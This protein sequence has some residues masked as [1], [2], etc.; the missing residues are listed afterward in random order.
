MSGVNTLFNALTHVAE[1][2]K[3]DFSDLKFA[4]GGGAAVQQSVSER[5]RAITKK[6]LIEGYGLSEASPVVCINPLAGASAIGTVGLPVPSTQVSIRD[7]HGQEVKLGEAGEVWV[8]GPQV[9]QG[10]WGKPE[11]TKHVLTD[12]GWLKTGDV[13]AIDERG[14]VRLLDRIKD[15][16][17]VSGFKVFPNEVEDVIA[18]HPGVLEA[19]VIGIPDERTGQA[20]KLFVVKRDQALTEA[21]ILAYARENLTGYKLPRAIEF[22]NELPKSSIGKILRKELR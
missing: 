7:D 12:D 8:R 19:A 14:F 15:M 6:P 5:W 20:V 2:A 11:E 18:R 9:M 22:R 10:Y 21:G 16:I 17:N 3:V 4:I 13:G 1:F